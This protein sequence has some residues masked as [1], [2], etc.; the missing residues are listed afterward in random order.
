M[1]F[2]SKYQ[3]LISLAFISLIFAKSIGLFSL[4]LG[5]LVLYANINTFLFLKNIERTGIVCTGKIIEYRL[6]MSYQGRF[7]IPVIEFIAKSGESIRAEPFIYTATDLSIFRSY[8][9]SLDQRVSIL[10]KQDDPRKFVIANEK[11]FNYLILTI[12]IIVA[13]IFIGL[14]IVIQLD[15]LQ[16]LG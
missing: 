1:K 8:K 4:F 2:I 16:A 11:T 5:I 13:M 10:Y 6:R 9:N 3:W 14:G 12:S 15:I 7:K